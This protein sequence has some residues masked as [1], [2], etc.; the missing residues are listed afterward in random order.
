MDVPIDGAHGVQSSS[1]TAQDTPQADGSV[2]RSWVAPSGAAARPVT[3]ADNVPD[4]TSP[5]SPINQGARSPRPKPTFMTLPAELRLVIYSLISRS[6]RVLSKSVLSRSL[7]SA[8]GSPEKVAENRGLEPGLVV[9]KAMVPELSKVCRQMKREYEDHVKS[10]SVLH[11]LIRNNIPASVT[12]GKWNV[13]TSGKI[14]LGNQE[15]PVAELALKI[16]FNPTDQQRS[17]SQRNYLQ[18]LERMAFYHH[19]QAGWNYKLQ[20][21][22]KM[23]Q[24]VRNQVPWTTNSEETDLAWVSNIQS[25]ALR[26]FDISLSLCLPRR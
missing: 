18:E 9:H 20:Q 26:L 2:L 21:C 8:D 13:K 6:S 11:V 24:E 1:R 14:H 23:A 25:R 3:R 17:H 7:Q 16:F 15:L 4:A 10:S 22:I 19:N 5:Q 12:G